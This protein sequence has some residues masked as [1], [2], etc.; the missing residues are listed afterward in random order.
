MRMNVPAISKRGESSSLAP[1]RILLMGHTDGQG[2]A[3]TAFKQLC[4][5]TSEE[6]HLVKIIV[7]SNNKISKQ[8]F[9]G[10][11]FLGRIEYTGPRLV[12]AVKKAM[13]VLNSGIKAW[14]FKPDIFVSVGLNTS[15]N[16]LG[17]FLGKRCFKVGQDFIAKRTVDDPVWKSGRK[18]M[19]GIVVQTPSMLKY[20]KELGRDTAR[21]NWLPCFP[22]ISEDGTLQRKRTGSSDRIKLGYF[23]RLAGNK[24]LDLLLSALANSNTPKNVKLDLWGTGQEEAA[25][26]QLVIELRLES[27]IRF[28]GPYP[29]GS[30][31]AALIASYDAVVLC[32]TGMEGLPLI[33]LEA[34]AYGLPFLATNVGAMEDCCI[35]NPDAVL[36]SP[37]KESISNGITLLVHKIQTGHFDATRQR[38]F[39][40]TTFSHQV[41]A[42]RWR[43]FF[44]NPKH[45]FLCI[46]KLFLSLELLDF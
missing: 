28:L 33:L 40:D 43:D 24:G 9:K 19:D 14:M 31:G 6:G 22:E 15:S 11:E 1:K 30:E 20:L 4:A 34:M 38:A 32:S 2:G 39:Y 18:F 21:V 29:S 27:V 35:D 26:K 45:F 10:V 17:W 41:M 23:G 46:I 3:Q 44:E 42:A 5:F 36:V 7:L 8:S 37:T 16:L 12:L 25:L 13:G